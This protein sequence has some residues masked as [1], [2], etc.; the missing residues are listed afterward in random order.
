LKYQN[1]LFTHS[2]I[3]KLQERLLKWKKKLIIFHTI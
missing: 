2:S 3:K 1:V